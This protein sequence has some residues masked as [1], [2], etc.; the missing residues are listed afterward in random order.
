MT[1]P[2]SPKI[3]R[4]RAKKLAIIIGSKRA[5][6]MAVRSVNKQQRYTQLALRLIQKEHFGVGTR[7]SN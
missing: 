1:H 6:G 5:I 3:F 2:I 7:I 4:S